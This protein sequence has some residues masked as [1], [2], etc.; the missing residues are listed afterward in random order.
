MKKAKHLAFKDVP[1]VVI[2]LDSL[3]VDFLG[4]SYVCYVLGFGPWD[5]LDFEPSR[6]NYRRLR[7]YYHYDTSYHCADEIIQD[8]YK[9][10]AW[11]IVKIVMS[12]KQRFTNYYDEAQR[13]YLKLFTEGHYD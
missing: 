11:H 8:F 4:C 3:N 7:H 12:D 13:K 6:R 2:Y 10:H 1:L 9:S 5:G